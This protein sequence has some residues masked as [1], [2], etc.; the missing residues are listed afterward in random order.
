MNRLMKDLAIDRSKN[1][2]AFADKFRPGEG[3]DDDDDDDGDGDED[4]DGGILDQCK[5]LISMIWAW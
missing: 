4:G 2:M 1:P 3:D 5:F